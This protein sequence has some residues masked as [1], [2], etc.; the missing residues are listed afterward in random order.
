MERS[1]RRIEFFKKLK[2]ID[3]LVRDVKKNKKIYQKGQGI[4]ATCLQ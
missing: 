1:T 4:K 3:P 2:T